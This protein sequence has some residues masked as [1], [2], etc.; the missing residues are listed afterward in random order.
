M[1]GSLL[2]A[3][4]YSENVQYSFYSILFGNTKFKKR[5]MIFP[6]FKFSLKCKEIGSLYLDGLSKFVFVRGPNLDTI[7]INIYKPK[8]TG[9]CMDT[10]KFYLLEYLIEQ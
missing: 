10:K 3:Y 8:P 1:S 9:F 4:L 5:Y 7:I 2:I 6:G